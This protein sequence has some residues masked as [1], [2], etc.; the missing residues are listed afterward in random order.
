MNSFS[1]SPSS[2]RIRHSIPNA[3]NVDLQLDL[4]RILSACIPTTDPARSF[5]LAN[6]GEQDGFEMIEKM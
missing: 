6:V 2:I 1:N 4:L 3:G 5:F